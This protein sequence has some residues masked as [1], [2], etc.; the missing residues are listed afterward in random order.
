MLRGDHPSHAST[1]LELELILGAITCVLELSVML[2]KKD[3]ACHL[4]K[5]PLCWN[6]NTNLSRMHLIRGAEAVSE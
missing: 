6:S 3:K 5:L 4:F 1:K 2:P